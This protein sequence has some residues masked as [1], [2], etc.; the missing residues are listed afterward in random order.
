MAALVSTSCSLE[1]AGLSRRDDDGRDAMAD[2]T[3]PDAGPMDSAADTAPRDTGLP[4]TAPLDTGPADTGPADTAVACTP[5][6]DHC[7]GELLVACVAGVSV[8]EDCALTDSYCDDSMASPVCTGWVCTP[9]Q[10]LCSGDAEE[11][12]CDDRGIEQTVSDCPR[13]CD[14]ATGRCRPTVPC[15]LTVDGTLRTGRMTFDTC[16]GG[17]D[18]TPIMGC[19]RTD[20]SGGDRILRLEV[21]VANRYR[22]DLNEAAGADADPVVY[23]RTAC[24]ERASELACDDDRPGTLNSRI[25]LDLEPGEY[26]IVM[27]SFRD[28]GNAQPGRCDDMEVNVSIR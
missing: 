16:A 25:E 2:A 18:A 13:G 5:A 8:A 11:T 28:D 12:S 26:F 9:G 7:E 22:V 15:A 19:T 20:I 21:P 14:S 24:D 1:T 17:D 6:G 4:D 10:S 27:D 3:S 23:L